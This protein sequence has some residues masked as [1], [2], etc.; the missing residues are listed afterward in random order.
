MPIITRGWVRSPPD[1]E[2]S[3]CSLDSLDDTASSVYDNEIKQL[4]ETLKDLGIGRLSDDDLSPDARPK[5]RPG[6]FKPGK[7][8]A[9][10][11]QSRSRTRTLDHA[12]HSEDYVPEHLVSPYMRPKVKGL[13]VRVKDD[14]EDTGIVSPRIMSRRRQSDPGRINVASLSLLQGRSSGLNSD[15]SE[16]DE[17][18]QE[19]RSPRARSPR[20]IFGAVPEDDYYVGSGSPHAPGW[21]SPRRRLLQTRHAQS[22]SHPEESPRRVRRK[23]SNSLPLPDRAALGVGEAIG[24]VAH[25]S[26]ESAGGNSQYRQQM[27]KR[28]RCIS[29]EESPLEAIMEEAGGQKAARR[30][31]VPT[32]MASTTASKRLLP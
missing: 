23:R 16:D 31:S 9:S 30:F 32:N 18:P 4:Q 14:V 24:A 27:L 19:L 25:L 26:P 3:S 20:R 6:E 17:A 11:R 7:Q 5:Q 28:S 21:G 13:Y 8:T 2:E 1:G 29:I 15:S 22:V 12:N 10:A